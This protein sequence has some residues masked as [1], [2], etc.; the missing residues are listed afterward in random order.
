MDPRHAQMFSDN[1]QEQ[2][3]KRMQMA[4]QAQQLL[5]QN[6]NAFTQLH[7]NGQPITTTLEQLQKGTGVVTGVI[8]GPGP[9]KEITMKLVRYVAVYPNPHVAKINPDLPVLLDGMAMISGSDE[10]RVIL[11]L[12]TELDTALAELNTALEEHTWI[13][14][15]GDQK[16]FAPVRRSDVEFKIEVVKN[17]L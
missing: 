12:A 15:D 16:P 14:Q 5:S 8:M 4:Y 17:Y 9:Q 11:D 13:N 6:V 3:S 2:L 7:W 1:Y 10:Q